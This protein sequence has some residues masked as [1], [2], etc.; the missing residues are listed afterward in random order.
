MLLPP[1]DSSDAWGGSK[2]D[3]TELLKVNRGLQKD[4]PTLKLFAADTFAAVL[5]LMEQHLDRGVKI[6]E[7]ELVARFERD[8]PAVG[9]TSQTPAQLIS[10]W[11]ERGWLHRIAD[12]VAP[13]ARRVCWLSSEAQTVLDIARRIRNDDSVAT[14]GSIIGISDRL[15]RVAR[16]LDN[17]P[18]RLLN[19]LDERIA[20]LQ[21]QR[22]Q[23]AAGNRPEPNF[24]DLEDEA[25]AIGMQMEHVVADIGRY[26]TIQN[27]ITTGL[28]SELGDS[29]AEFRDRH[30]KLFDDYLALDQSREQ[31]S[32]QAFTRMIQDP[33]AQLRLRRDIDLVAA[34]LPDLDAGVKDLLRGFLTSVSRQMS[35]VDRV[36]QRCA[37]RIRRFFAAGTAEQSRGFARQLNEAIAA[38]QA[39]LNVSLTDSQL[40]C[41]IPIVTSEAETSLG[42]LG[43]KIVDPTPPPLAQESVETLDIAGFAALAAQVDVEALAGAVNTALA[44]G[45]ISL[46]EALMLVDDAYLGE[47]L[48]LWT[49]AQA[50]PQGQSPVEAE[51]TVQFRSMG[52][53]DRQMRVPLLMFT[54][55]VI[56]GDLL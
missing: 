13:G 26:A 38:G 35:E 44:A 25:K 29:D 51:A 42:A 45:P 20:E 30:H 19:D 55:P 1:G 43:F 17:D 16:Q 47:L 6:A 54:E 39:L 34:G 52:G 4:S 32:Y 23:V 10:I 33:A 53:V 14:G 18:D 8:M 41:E 50:Q 15:K 27:R 24:L 21:R 46:P 36:R 12:D 7:T 48:V 2:V 5:A 22:E 9:L 56:E 40:D 31:A 11:A 28:L 3:L 37:Q 49:W